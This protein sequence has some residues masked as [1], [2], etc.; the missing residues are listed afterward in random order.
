MSRVIIFS[1]NPDESRRFA[2]LVRTDD[3]SV[4]ESTKPLEV[5]HILKNEPVDIVLASDT[6]SDVEKDVFRNMIESISP[7]VKVMFVGTPS[8]DGRIYFSPESIGQFL[9][10]N[11]SLITSLREKIRG[12]KNFSIS[13]TDRLLQIFEVEDKYFFN[14]CH[15]TAEFSEKIA[16]R[17]GFDE[18][19][20]ESI[21]MVAL[22][23]DLGRVGIQNELLEA[24][25]RFDQKEMISL[26]KHPLNTVEML[27]HLNF[28]WSIEAII[29][30]HHEHYDGSGY[31]MGLKGRQISIGARIIHM[32]ESYV[33][34]TADR[35]YRK[36]LTKEQA[37]KEMVKKAGSQFDPEIA[38]IFLSILKEMPETE[39]KTSVLL[40]ERSPNVASLLKLGIDASKMEVLSVSNSFDA[41]RQARLRKPDLII[42]DVEIFEADTFA[43]FFHRLR[44]VHTVQDKPFMLIIPDEAYAKRYEGQ[45]I[46][47]LTKPVDMS[48]L[49]SSINS[50]LSGKKVRPETKEEAAGLTGS[51]EDFGLDDIMQILSLGLK[52]AKVEVVSGVKKGII[53]TEAGRV[54]YTATGENVGIAAFSEMVG[55]SDGSFLIRHGKK[56]PKTNINMNTTQLLLESTKAKDIRSA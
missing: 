32:A 49:V 15:L 56:A 45:D 47:Y 25:R 54:V 28:P 4:I 42:I 6:L 29:A 9:R 52:T 24:D 12:L 31:P 27:R 36:A 51:L 20:V 1:S 53:Y 38:E 18:E 44:R 7:G 43:S 26:K 13:F 19:M 10:D 34:M 5:L 50:I 21:R 30:Q 40:I 55:W 37:M 35:P 3:I 46:H 14:N 22:V 2:N 48:L 33:A 23:K 16:R 17:M 39:D 41:L 8:V 11:V